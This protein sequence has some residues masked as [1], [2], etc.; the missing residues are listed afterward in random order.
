MEPLGNGLFV[1]QVNSNRASFNSRTDQSIS[2]HGPF[3]TYLHRFGSCSHDGG[4]SDDESD[5]DH[6]APDCPVTKPSHFTNSG[7]ENLS[8]WCEN[9][10][11]DKKSLAR[12]M[13]IHERRHDTIID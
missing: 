13:K 12:L 4:V 3:V 6:Y 7:A 8:T 9:I 1:P 11:P 2:G 5:P 10:L